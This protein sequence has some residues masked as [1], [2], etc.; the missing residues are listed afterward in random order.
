MVCQ[1]PRSLVNRRTD[2]KEHP[3]AAHPL[4]GRGKRP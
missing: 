1:P 4:G 2:A 3:A